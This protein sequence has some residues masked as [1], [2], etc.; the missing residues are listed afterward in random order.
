[1][2]P[3]AWCG[4]RPRELA[5]IMNR[6][7][8]TNGSSAQ[9]FT[10]RPVRKRPLS[11]ATVS[12]KQTPGGPVWAF[13]WRIKGRGG[14]RPR[15]Y[16]KFRM[17]KRNAAHLCKRQQHL[18]DNRR[19]CSTL[20][21]CNFM[22]ASPTMTSSPVEVSRPILYHTVVLTSILLGCS[23]RDPETVAWRHR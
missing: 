11:C 19:G 12:L 22:H 21:D 3:G 15:C 4:V 8:R 1:M 6:T 5:F 16:V 23:F 14:G 10:P 18:T 13:S 2:R 20:L 7:C 17:S 9:S